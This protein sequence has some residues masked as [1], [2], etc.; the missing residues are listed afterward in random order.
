[1]SRRWPA[2][3]LP[4]LGEGSTSPYP[5]S[6]PP[7]EGAGYRPSDIRE[8][9]PDLVHTLTWC[10]DA[11][12]RR[13]GDPDRPA[14]RPDA[15]PTGEYWTPTPLSYTPTPQKFSPA[16]RAKLGRE[17]ERGGGRRGGRRGPREV[18]RGLG[19]VLPLPR[20]LGGSLEGPDTLPD[21]SDA[22]RNARRRPVIAAAVASRARRPTPDAPRRLSGYP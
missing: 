1:M 13:L 19:K 21:A 5:P 14:R 20:A 6:P 8:A 10:P 17:G 3:L 2:G 4:G 18:G 22:P 12:A 16:P 9:V 15:R 7:L 11:D